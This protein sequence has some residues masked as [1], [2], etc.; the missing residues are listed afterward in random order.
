[1]PLNSARARQLLKEFNFRSLF[2]DELGWD[3]HNGTLQITLDGN[4]TSLGALAQKRGM[5]A[6]QFATPAGERIQAR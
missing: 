6:Y 5:V 4:P 2:R 3:N 1:M